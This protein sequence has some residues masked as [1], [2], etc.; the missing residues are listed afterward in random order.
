MF[1]RIAEFEVT[2]LR[3]VRHVRQAADKHVQGGE[4]TP[5]NALVNLASNR[6]DE[7]ESF[8]DPARWSCGRRRSGS[9][10]E[11]L[12]GSSVFG[13][14]HRAVAAAAWRRSSSFNP[15][16]SWQGQP[17]VR[18]VLVDLRSLGILTLAALLLTQVTG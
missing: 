18:Q 6:I 17:Y 12:M 16:I 14:A 13:S 2:L 3:I 15:R 10:S 5:I 9:T 7:R 4:L 11:S 8:F 1:D